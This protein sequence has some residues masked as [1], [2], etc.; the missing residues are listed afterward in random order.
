[1]GDLTRRLSSRSESTSGRSSQL[2]VSDTLTSPGSDGQDGDAIQHNPDSFNGVQFSTRHGVAADTPMSEAGASLESS[3]AG[4]EAPVSKPLPALNPTHAH[5]DTRTQTH[6]HSHTHT[7]THTHKWAQD[8]AGRQG[9][10]GTQGTD[11]SGFLPADILGWTTP[12]MT[13]DALRSMLNKSA[14]QSGG[15]GDGDGAAGKAFA[16]LSASAGDGGP[17]DAPPP[18]ARD[19]G[20]ME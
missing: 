6:T 17:P 10:Q 11:G 7:H 12:R 3:Q 18:V 14:A 15:G 8:M 20:M 19:V 4:A 1:M 16:A 9:K 13:R 2:K 5:R